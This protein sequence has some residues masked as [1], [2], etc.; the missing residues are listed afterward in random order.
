MRICGVNSV[1][2]ISLSLILTLR[3][4]RERRQMKERKG[5]EER[6]GKGMVSEGAGHN[7]SVQIQMYWGARDFR[8]GKTLYK[9]CSPPQYM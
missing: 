7:I 2:H 1:D 3:S 9:I 6:R 8:G 4:S 5:A